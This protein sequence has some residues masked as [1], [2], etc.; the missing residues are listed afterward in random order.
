VNDTRYYGLYFDIPA[1][2]YGP[3]GEGAHGF[4]E[5]TDLDFLKT[6]TLAIAGFIADWCGLKPLD[7]DA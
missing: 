3:L 2:C 6:T 4:D 7:E 1:L 5:R